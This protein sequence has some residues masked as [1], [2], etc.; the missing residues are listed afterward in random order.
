MIK[1]LLT[2]LCS[3]LLLTACSA[4]SFGLYHASYITK[5]GKYFGHKNV[6]VETFT[7]LSVKGALEDCNS[8][9][10]AAKHNLG[11]EKTFGV[12]TSFSSCKLDK[13]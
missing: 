10:N 12:H 11:K 5:T 3:G 6:K 1:K 8:A 4:S 13:K 9:L 2:I 7:G